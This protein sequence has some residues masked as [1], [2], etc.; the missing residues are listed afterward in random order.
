MKKKKKKGKKQAKG[1]RSPC[2]AQAGKEQT[3][4]PAQAVGKALGKRGNSRH[5]STPALSA[6][7]Q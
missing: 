5:S 3:H 4:L 6:A 2:E 1:T 7:K